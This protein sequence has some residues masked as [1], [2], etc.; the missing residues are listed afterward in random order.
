MGIYNVLP[1]EAKLALL[2]AG[3]IRLTEAGQEVFLALSEKF[4][5]L[6]NEQRLQ[7]GIRPTGDAASKFKN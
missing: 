2:R 1:G 5:T 6:Q 3:F 4:V 7:A